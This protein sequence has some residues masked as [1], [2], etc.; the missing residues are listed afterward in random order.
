M[1]LSI[2]MQ[3][4]FPQWNAIDYLI[5]TLWIQTN[6]AAICKFISAFLISYMCVLLELFEP[7]ITSFWV[8]H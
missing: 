3:M 4:D 6:F 1:V 7:V 8:P 5:I 2:E